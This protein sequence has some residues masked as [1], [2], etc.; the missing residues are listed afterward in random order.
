MADLPTDTD[1]ILSVLCDFG[2][3][4]ILRRWRVDSCIAST[5]I[6]IEVLAY[7]G[8]PAEPLPV[9]TRV[10]SPA[11][12]RLI[13]EGRDLNTVTPEEC[14]QCWIVDIGFPPGEGAKPPDS[15]G[16]WWCHM[17]ILALGRLIIDLSLDQAARPEK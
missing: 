7:F 12:V 9:M 8:I 3:K 11:A 10:I 2:R 15:E 13:D 14:P 6:G 1:L 16:F 5:R 17:V 4:A